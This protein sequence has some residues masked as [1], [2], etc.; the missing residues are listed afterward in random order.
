MAKLRL[1]LIL[2][3][4]FLGRLAIAAAWVFAVA[5]VVWNLARLYPGDRWSLVRLG[6]YLA[7]WLFMALAPA[8]VVALMAR[9]P[10][11]VR[12]LALLTLVFAVRYW[13]LL[14]PRLSLLRAESSTSELRVMTFNVNYANRNVPAISSLILAESPD[15]IAFQELTGRLAVPLRNELRAEYPYFQYDYSQGLTALMSR[16]PLTIQPVPLTVSHT[17][18][19]AVETPDGTV[20]IW[21]VHLSTAISQD[22]WEWQKGMA[23]VIAEEIGNEPGPMILLGD[24]NTTDQT[25]NYRLIADR[26]NDVHWAVGRGF[27]FTFPDI[28]QPVDGAPVLRPVVRIDH[29]F[30]SEHFAP[31]EIYVAASS[32]GSDHRPVVA[33]LRVSSR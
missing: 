6:N 25:E 4:R 21:N 1:H 13:P 29:I 8:L 31:Q 19:A 2:S 22:G 26:L 27:A 5:L 30:T 12:I 32:Y 23:T 33:T 20:E 15:V 16:Y 18:R 17:Q 14:I 11:L 3:L 7:P 10:W 28:R 24:F 9:R